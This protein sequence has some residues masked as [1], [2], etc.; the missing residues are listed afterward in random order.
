M[1]GFLILEDG[2][3]FEGKA[4][5]EPS[6]RICEVVFNTGMAG[7]VES[8]S[9]P[10][11]GSQGVAL[12]FPAIGNHGVCQT[13]MESD[14]PAL[15]ALIVREYY[16]G[17]PDVRADMS[18][19]AWLKS[20]HIPGL[21]DVDTRALTRHLRENG[22]MKGMLTYGARP[23]FPAVRDAIRSWSMPPQVPAASIQA[24]CFYPHTS[25][26][27]G[28]GRHIAVVDYG[29]KRNMIRDLNRIGADVTLLPYDASA[30]Y[31]LGLGVGGIL[32]S[33][34]PGDPK[35][36]PRQIAEIRRL[37]DAGI[38]MMAICLGHQM[39]ALSVGMDTEK[40]L[41]GH[42]G[43]NHPVRDCRTGRLYVTSQNHGYVVR[44]ESLSGADYDLTV[45]FEH[46]NDSSVEGLHFTDR[47]IDSYQFHPEASP[48]PEDTFHLF[49]DFLKRVKS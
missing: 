38:P 18:L 46:V 31:I 2:M 3:I 33:N 24:E 44:R 11:Y 48:G 21:W 6:E 9:D 5:G 28:S 20:E 30:D 12:T 45:S 32:L 4:F 17:E 14:R 49:E 1:D 25:E 37:V 43:G 19:D 13:D 35:N 15:A 8:I 41:F 23:S 26:G 39:L 40:M 16:D 34:G 10:S 7:Y 27:A 29:T 36:C 47:P 42:R 22:T